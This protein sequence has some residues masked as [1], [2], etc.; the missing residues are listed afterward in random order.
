MPIDAKAVRPGDITYH[1][2]MD[3]ESAQVRVR[4]EPWAMLLW[5]NG[6]ARVEGYP[7]NTID[8]ARAD[9]LL[10]LSAE[11]LKRARKR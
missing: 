7:N 2:N 6:V 4:G 1:L 11:A 3:P 10:M 5:H 8:G 9:V